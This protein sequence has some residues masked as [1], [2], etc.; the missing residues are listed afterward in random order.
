MPRVLLRAPT[1]EDA[2]PFVRLA[3]LSRERDRWLATPPRTPRQFATYVAR[4]GRSDFDARL[5]C[6]K[7]TGELVGMVNA[8]QI[9]RGGFRSAYLG[10]WVGAPFEGQGL[11]R[12]AVTL[13]LKRMF[14]VLRL[15]R[16]E[17][18]IQPGNRR[19][20]A[21]AKGLGFR[22]EGYSPRYLRF[23]GEWRDHVRFALTV[24]EWRTR[25]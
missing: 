2:G 4:A 24:E 10:Y 17:A 23:D 1:L 3:R 14:G 20:L 9:Y 13:M 16:I 18:N 7:A 21:L 19:S 6:L 22:R 11:M 8:S 15:H 5:V 12:E 25:L